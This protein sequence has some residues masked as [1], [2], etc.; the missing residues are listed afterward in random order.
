MRYAEFYRIA[1]G[2]LVFLIG[3]AL[4]LAGAQLWKGG[5]AAWPE[6]VANDVIVRRTAY[7]LIIMAALLLITGIATMRG[8]SWGSFVAAIVLIIFVVIAFWGNHLLF[9]DIRPL[10]TITN[11]IVAAI[12]LA[13]LRVGVSR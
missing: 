11:V 3:V 4:S 2:V 6:I 12:I 8:V 9:G 1:G 10:H 7:G 13:L 5:P